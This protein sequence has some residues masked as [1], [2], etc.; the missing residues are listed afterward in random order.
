MHEKKLKRRQAIY[1]G[2]FT[3]LIG[4]IVIIGFHT[5]FFRRIDYF[6]YDL[7]FF[8][9]GS[10]AQSNGITL[11]FIDEQS[12]LELHSNRG[13][14]SRPQLASALT[15]LCSAGAGAVGLDVLLLY[16][17]TEVAQD[18]TLAKAI[19][20]CGNV[21]LARVSS[22]STAGELLPAAVFRKEMAGDGFI[23]LPLDEDAVL[24]KLRFLNARPAGQEGL[25]LLPSFALELARVYLN[26]DFTLDFSQRDRF[27]L[28][29]AGEKKLSLPYPDLLI[30]YKGSYRSFPHMSFADAVLGRIN[31]ENVKGRIILIGSAMAGHHDFFSTP[32]SRFYRSSNRLKDKFAEMEESVLGDKDPGVACHAHAVE[33]IITQAFIKRPAKGLI[34]GFIMLATLAGSFF[35]LPKRGVVM[36]FTV[37]CLGL[38]TIILLSYWAFAGYSLAI[39]TA[40]LLFALSAQF[41]CGLVNQKVFFRKRSMAVTELFGKYVS[42]KVVNELLKSDLDSA[43]EG[44]KE[45]VTI[46]FADIR[47]FTT[48]TERLGP[49]ETA[50][51]LNEYFGKMLPVI[52]ENDGTIDKLV[53]DAVI[54]FF[55]APILQSDHAN[56]GVL[57]AFEMVRRL[58]ELNRESAIFRE[59]P[60]RIG[61]GINTGEVTVGNMGGKA[62]M[63]YTIIGDAVNLA[64]RIESQNKVYGT[65]ILLSAETAGLLDSRFITR[66]LGTV[67]VKGREKPVTLYEL[68]GVNS[69]IS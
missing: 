11:V 36:E 46:L 27:S 59:Q 17:E 1:S 56:K 34:L 50:A 47:D 55:G 23:D 4:V 57:T 42:P 12:A 5:G 33:T 51:L 43:L 32:Y 62:F 9:R 38:I 65:T 30:N 16:P 26:L 25:E 15:N 6:L 63:N 37:L 58:E 41:I 49:K 14:W 69:E 66:E 8:W 31:P 7:N 29:S 20:E 3:F 54:A 19:R 28:G 44:R 35:Y 22:V 67:K 18:D 52:V 68:T 13:G 53:G 48:L 24:R 39:S 21:V 2:I 60:L 64:S 40:P 61:I 10:Q 45:T